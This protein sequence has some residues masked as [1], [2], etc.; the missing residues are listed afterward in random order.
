[1]NRSKLV[2]GAI[3]AV[4]AVGVTGASAQNVGPDFV[5]QRQDYM[6]SMFRGGIATFR[7]YASGE[8]T[9]AAAVVESA[10]RLAAL[11]GDMNKWFPPG[12]DRDSLAGSRA[13]P[14]VWTKKAEFDA[15]S[16]KLVDESKKLASIAASG[17]ADAIKSQITATV[18]ACGG[19]HGGPGATGGTFRFE[20]PQ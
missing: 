9:N 10:T 5:K 13:K 3:A 2:L 15:A 4:I 1:M 17:N 20:K 14:E 18:T 12:T 7:K 6:S 11:A 16:A 19:C 8:E